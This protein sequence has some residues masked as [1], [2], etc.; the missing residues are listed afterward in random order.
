MV[1]GVISFSISTFAVS[2]SSCPGFAS[3]SILPNGLITKEGPVLAA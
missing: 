3:A 2:T 1:N